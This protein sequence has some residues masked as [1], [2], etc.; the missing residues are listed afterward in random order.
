MI[1]WNTAHV[2]LQHIR[3]EFYK[4][5]IWHLI[6]RWKSVLIIKET[7]W[8]N[9]LDFIK[10]VSITRKFHCNRYHGFWEKYRRH[11]FCTGL[12]IIAR[13]IK[14]SASAFKFITLLK[15][16]CDLEANAKARWQNM[17]TIYGQI[18]DCIPYITK[19]KNCPQKWHGPTTLD[20]ANKLQT[21]IQKILK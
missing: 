21:A 6:Q 3:R 16:Y 14:T 19:K 18:W 4:T 9:N 7:L 20:A 8:K 13:S 15:K 2:K 10:N 11:Y 1:S 12:H 5:G 17:H